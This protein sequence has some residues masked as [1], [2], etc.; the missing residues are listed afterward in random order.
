MIKTI[1][2]IG[3]FRKKD[4]YEIVRNGVELFRKNRIYVNSPMG[5][6]VSRSIDKFVLFETDPQ[7]LSP[8]D[9]Q[10]ITLDKILKEA[11]PVSYFIYLFF[12]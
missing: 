3:S 1:A 2:F 12:T 10:M 9:I 4:H 6:A 11:L 8:S 7:D 5:S